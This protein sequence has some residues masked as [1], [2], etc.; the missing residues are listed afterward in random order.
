MTL[1]RKLLASLT[2]VAA[3]AG[4]MLFGTVG[5]M[6]AANAGITTSIEAGR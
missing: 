2:T 3:A 6:T 5:E 4:L 1:T